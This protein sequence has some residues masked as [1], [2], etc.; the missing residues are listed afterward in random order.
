VSKTEQETLSITP[1]ENLNPQL[2][3]ADTQHQLFLLA[4]HNKLHLAPI[5]GDVKNVLDTGTGTSIWVIDLGMTRSIP[6]ILESKS[7]I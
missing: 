5:D 3:R 4:F 6:A 7:L 2:T 1:E